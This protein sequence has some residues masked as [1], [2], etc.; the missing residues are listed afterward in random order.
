VSRLGSDDQIYQAVESAATAGAPLSAW[1]AL[2][3]GHTTFKASLAAI[4]DGTNLVRLLAIGTDSAIY[5]A[6]ETAR[7]S[8]AYGSWTQVGG[9]ADLAV[10]IRA[11]LNSDGR[12]EVF[13]VAPNNQIFHAAEGAPGGA[14]DPWE[15]LG[16]VSDTTPAAIDVG[17]DS[18]GFL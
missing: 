14:F 7:G 5:E 16:Q 8:A 17:I 18:E 12:L 9:S 4:L 3:S 13:R 11:G 6:A 10:S 15:Q 1:T 2:T